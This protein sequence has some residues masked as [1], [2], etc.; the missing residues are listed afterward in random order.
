MYFTAYTSTSADSKMVCKGLRNQFRII[1]SRIIESSS[2][3]GKRITFL[4]LRQAANSLTEDP[5]SQCPM[6]KPLEALTYDEMS[7]SCERVNFS[8]QFGCYEGVC[9]DG[10]TTICTIILA[11]NMQGKLLHFFK[12]KA[13]SMQSVPLVL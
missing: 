10:I 1:E 6:A 3:E 8:A 7:T 2:R 13:G 4:H 5:R 12:F 9:S 11:L